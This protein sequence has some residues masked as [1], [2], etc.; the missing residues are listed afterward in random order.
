MSV[1]TLSIIIANFNG[2]EYLSTC[3]D[4]I[5]NSTYQAFECIICDDGSTDQSIEIITNYQKKDQRIILKRNAS[6]LGAAAS[7]NIAVKQAQGTVLFFLDNDTEI[8]PTTIYEIIQTINS[9][10]SIGAC[11]AM[12]MDFEQ[13]NLIQNAGMKLWAATGWGLPIDQWQENKGQFNNQ[14]NEIIAISA[15]LAVK[16][17]VF[18]IIN[19]FDQD[20][21]VVTEDLDLCWRIWIAGYRIVLAPTAIVYHWTKPVTKRKNT[22]QTTQNISFHLTKNSLIS[23]CKNYQTLNAIKYFVQSI[24]INFGKGILISIKRRELA[25][26]IGSIKAL[27]WFIPQ[28]PETLKKRQYVNSYRKTSDQALLASIILDTKISAIYQ[29]YFAQSKLA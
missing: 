19:G 3:L 28:L 23:I 17:S 25:S 1:P 26:L 22:R 12:I 29:K 16:K 21:A 2:E 11:Q 9:Q 4:S 27:V 8:L 14:L 10:P 7:R 15:A 13:R 6:N 5:L 24:I 18:E 20:E